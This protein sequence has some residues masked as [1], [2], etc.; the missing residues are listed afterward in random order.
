[1]I[2]KRPLSEAAFFVGSVGSAGGLMAP[3]ACL[4]DGVD[5]L[6]VA[7]PARLDHLTDLVIQN[8]LPPVEIN[9]ENGV[10]DAEIH[11]LKDNDLH[12]RFGPAKGAEREIFDD[13]IV[14][15]VAKAGEEFLRDLPV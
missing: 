13:G 4:I 9:D 1:M 15:T 10:G 11:I 8:E 3:P 6:V 5:R 2:K 12:I 14:F 7:D